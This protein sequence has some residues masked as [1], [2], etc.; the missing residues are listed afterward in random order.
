[1]QQRACRGPQMG[2]NA[3]VTSQ[4]D[5]RGQ[6]GLPAHLADVSCAESECQSQSLM[7]WWHAATAVS[8]ERL[9]RQR[10]DPYRRSQSPLRRWSHLQP[11]TPSKSA[12]HCSDVI[13]SLCS[14]THHA[15]G[16]VR[17]GRAA[18]KINFS[19]RAS[20]QNQQQP[21]GGGAT[22]FERF[23]L[24]LQCLQCGLCL[25]LEQRILRV[26][27]VALRMFNAQRHLRR[28]SRDSAAHHLHLSQSIA[29]LIHQTERS[30]K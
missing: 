12:E 26:V 11:A 9:N 17:G 25:A 1:M 8:A 20:E 30:N 3:R 22:G 10:T 29:V 15:C 23:L 27:D 13:R 5:E 6:R 24:C 2:N 19:S 28:L 7:R 18:T 16:G 21:Q 14:R 4:T